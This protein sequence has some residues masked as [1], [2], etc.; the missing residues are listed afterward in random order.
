MPGEVRR[1]IDII[2]QE[3][4]R[5]NP[6]LEATTKTKLLLKG[7]YIDKFTSTSADDP[8]IIEKIKEVAAEMGVTL[9]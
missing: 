9:Q 1:L 6:T 4:A 2:I 7:I 3:R 8:E 5:G